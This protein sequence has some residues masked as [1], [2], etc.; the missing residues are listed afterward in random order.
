M[1]V[2]NR[3]EHR[4]RAADRNDLSRLGEIARTSLADAASLDLAALQKEENLFVAEWRTAIDGF[5]VLLPLQSS[6]LISRL[7]VAEEARKQGLGAWLLDCAAFHARSLDLV[8]VEIQRPEQDK[9]GIAWL[10][11]RGFVRNPH[12]GNKI[13]LSRSV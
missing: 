2:S 10:A 5:M 11:K 8:A 13:Y 3:I 4:L 6:L 12:G 9:A 7:V 1:A